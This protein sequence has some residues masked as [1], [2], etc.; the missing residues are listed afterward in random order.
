MGTDM[1]ANCLQSIK[2]LIQTNK[3]GILKMLVK[4]YIA[5][6]LVILIALGQ[7]LTAFAQVGFDVKVNYDGVNKQATVSGIVYSESNTELTGIAAN[8]TLLDS[9]GGAV[10]LSNPSFTVDGANVLQDEKGLFYFKYPDQV[11]NYLPGE[12]YDYSLNVG[13]TSLGNKIITDSYIPSGGPE[14]FVKTIDGE[15][16]FD[17]G[18]S[19]YIY[20]KMEA[21]VDIGLAGF[22]SGMSTLNF[23]AKSSYFDKNTSQ[24]ITKDFMLTFNKNTQTNEYFAK[25]NFVDAAN[26]SAS[27]E[28]YTAIPINPNDK[29]IIEINLDDGNGK[30]IKTC[31]IEFNPFASSGGDPIKSNLQSVSHNFDG[32]NNY[33]EFRT[34]LQEGS[35]VNVQSANMVRFELKGM[36][37][38]GFFS[39]NNININNIGIVS[40]SDTNGNK[41]A[42][43]N[44]WGVFNQFDEMTGSGERIVDCGI[45]LAEGQLGLNYDTSYRINFSGGLMDMLMKDISN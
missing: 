41:I 2:K 17:P 34:P 30:I 35:T 13:G 42:T 31:S 15:S 16:Y 19:R 8:S 28:P 1:S 33:I 26:Y 40:L 9:T 37:P 23:G 12:K 7:A 24:N 44:I 22:E 25:A 21:I 3:G 39:Q 4:K 32:I 14:F 6:V 38:D 18:C 43:Q 10:N 45:Q 5:V 29:N 27:Q 20:T 11:F 36:V